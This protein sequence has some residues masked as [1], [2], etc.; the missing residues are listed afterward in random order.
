MSNRRTTSIS[1]ETAIPT[2]AQMRTA[3]ER[4]I[5]LHLQIEENE[6][7]LKQA[8]EA[9]KAS[10]AADTLPS[11]TQKAEQETILLRY[12]EA[13]PELFVKRQKHEVYGGHKIGWQISPPAVVLVKQA[14]QKRKQTWPG[15]IES[16]KA[17]GAWA[18]ALVRTVEEPDKEAVLALHR[19]AAGNEDATEL[20][21]AESAL[22]QLGVKVTQEERFVI[23]LNLQPEAPKA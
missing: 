23:D 6:N 7:E 2:E 17:V 1:P 10:F 19:A 14:G 20:V 4:Y 18:L 16:C 22:A 15:F 3:L 11:Q 12:A 8:I 21:R 9:M 13:H 5:E